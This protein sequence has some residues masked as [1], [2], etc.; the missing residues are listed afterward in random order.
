V[1]CSCPLCSTCL[2]VCSMRHTCALQVACSAGASPWSR[3]A[4]LYGL[5]EGA[6][7]RST[8]Q[9]SAAPHNAIG[10]TQMLRLCA[11]APKGP[12][13]R[14]M[15]RAG[16]TSTAGASGWSTTSSGPWAR[17]PFSPFLPLSVLQQGTTPTRAGP[18]R[19]LL[20]DVGCRLV[21]VP[22]DQAHP[23]A[24][25]DHPCPCLCPGARVAPRRLRKAPSPAPQGAAARLR[26][27]ARGR[28]APAL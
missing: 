19:L 27:Q 24:D 8:T 17:T 16:R 15:R 28:E 1:V 9:C 6:A 23:D 7:C 11:G 21:R 5:L 22:V 12:W 3:L 14:S 18:S 10:T 25:E 13:Q 4:A 2:C 26:Q 20:G